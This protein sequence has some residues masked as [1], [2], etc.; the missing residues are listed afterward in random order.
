MRHHNIL[1]IL[2]V[3]SRMLLANAGLLEVSAT[4]FFE[5]VTKDEFTAQMAQRRAQISARDSWKKKLRIVW[6]GF[7]AKHR[8]WKVERV[9]VA[10]SQARFLHDFACTYII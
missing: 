9:L 1:Y 10:I 8:P 3:S 5:K 4:L 6:A 7:H 2:N